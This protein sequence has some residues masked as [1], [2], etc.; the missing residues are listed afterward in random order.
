M[1]RI[2][3]SPA[4]T[5]SLT[6][7]STCA[8]TPMT[9]VA[10]LISPEEGSTRPGATVCQRLSSAASSRGARGASCASVRAASAAN[11]NTT[12]AARWAADLLFDP[13]MLFGVIM[14]CAIAFVFFERLT[15]ALF[16][17]DASIFDVNY[18]VGEA[19]Y[20]R[21]VCDHQHPA[22]AILGDLGQ[23][24]H[25][26]IAVLAVE[27]GGWLVRENGRW[28]SHDRPCDGDALLFAAAEFE[29][30]CV[31]FVGETDHGQGVLGPGDGVRGV[32][33]AHVQ[34]Q[35][36]VVRSRQGRKQMVGLKDEPH[37]LA[38]EL[39]QLLGPGS[40][41]GAAAHPDRSACGRQHASEDRQQRGL[42]AAG[43]PH[44]QR[45]FA[46]PERQAYAL[47][48]LDLSRP[49]A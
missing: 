9:G 47:E 7:T 1:S 23:Q 34:R 24:R 20:T 44:Q 22:R 49:L 38:P 46:A 16:A 21:V 8:I 15:A 13:I 40:F 5:L 18:S 19:Q 11:A 27:G 28:L 39:G 6:L 12:A 30:K 14:D 33:A 32:V 4:D 31:G 25:D 3:G 36:D 48:R 45:Q 43:G 41:R 10:I 42:A 2:S 17:H 26:R 37:M 29:R 35:S